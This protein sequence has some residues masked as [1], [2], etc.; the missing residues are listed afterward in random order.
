MSDEY[1]KTVVIRDRSSVPGSVLPNGEGGAGHR[2]SN[3]QVP[4]SDVAN[5]VAY[6]DFEDTSWLT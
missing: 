5:D 2:H 1:T 4:Q 6:P 3:H